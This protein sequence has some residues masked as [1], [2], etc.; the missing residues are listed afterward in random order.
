ML[1]LKRLVAFIIVGVT[2][3]STG[4]A[5]AATAQWLLTGLR[6]YL[7]ERALGGELRLVASLRLSL[8]GTAL[9]S[10]AVSGTIEPGK[11]ADLILAEAN[12]LESPGTLA[13]P[14]G[15]MARGRWRTAAELRAMIGPRE[16]PER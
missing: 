16:G 11:R 8:V 9:G 10:L 6:F 13:E 3:L 15:V 7:W 5:L 1:V 14:V 4:A 2:S 12:P